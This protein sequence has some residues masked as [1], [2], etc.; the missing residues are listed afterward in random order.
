MSNATH[1]PHASDGQEQRYPGW[2]KGMNNILADHELP[3]D[4][5]RAAVNVDVLDSGKVRR[6]KGSTQLSATATHSLWTNG[7]IALC[8]A[9][10]ALNRLNANDSLTSLAS[11][12]SG[13]PISFTEAGLDIYWSDGIQHGRISGGLALPWGVEVPG[14]PPSLSTGAGTLETG[15]YMAAITFTTAT[16]EES[17]ASL[18]NTASVTTGA[19]TLTIP[20]PT[21][22]AVTSINVYLTQANGDVLYQ[23]ASIAV[24]VPRME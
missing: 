19:L 24:G 4:V 20:Q 17:A 10:G 16:G 6:R 15:V 18:V 7:S 5:L 21:E 8:Y 9:S 14:R 11:G 3:T 12:L 22:S 23:I 1:D 2:S 13:R